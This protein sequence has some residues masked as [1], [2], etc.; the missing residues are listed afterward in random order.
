MKILQKEVE[1]NLDTKI[2]L[3]A[4]HTVYYVIKHTNQGRLKTI[5]FGFNKILVH[6]Q[7]LL[8]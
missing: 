4:H 5:M 2:T 3:Y 6:R 7:V 1:K 8:P